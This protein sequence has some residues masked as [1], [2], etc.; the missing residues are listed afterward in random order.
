MRRGATLTE[1][2]MAL[3]IMAV[4]IVSVFTLFPLSILLSIRSHTLTEARIHK[5]NAAELI[6]SQPSVLTAP[7]MESVYVV[8]PLGWYAAGDE[9][10]NADNFGGMASALVRTNGGLTRDEA[11]MFC[12]HPDG[13]KLEVEAVPSSMTPTVVTFPPTVELPQLA[14]ARARPELHRLL[15]GGVTRPIHSISGQTVTLP[16]NAPL[17]G[18]AVDDLAA[19]EVADRRVTWLVTVR[20]DGNRRNANMAIFFSRSFSP[21]D[22][23]AYAS[24]WADPQPDQVTITWGAGEA[25]PLLKPGSWILDAERCTWIAIRNVEES[26]SSAVVTLDRIVPT[27]SMGQAILMR[28]IVNVFDLTL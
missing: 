7:P 9:G 21:D 28:S 15:I 25:K 6:R 3:L 14:Q 18:I 11:R 27:D 19:V 1:V 24:S 2:L 23:H 20:S 22:E 16:A 5:N 12:E 26:A 10:V 17:V 13:W 8:D 4:G